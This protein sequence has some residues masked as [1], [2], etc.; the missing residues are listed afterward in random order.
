MTTRKPQFV[1]VTY[2]QTTPEKVWAALQDPEL[3][4]QFWGMH[5]NV[6]DWKAGS[7]WSHQDYETNEVHLTGQV[8]EAE[9]PKKLV[10]T[11]GWPEGRPGAEP[12][13]KVTFLLE[14]FMGSVRLTVMHDELVEG[15]ET[16]KGISQGW[17][18][19]LSSLKSLL[20]T[21]Q[22]LAM[23]TKRWGG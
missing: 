6:S 18:A 2:I 16:M 13:S 22:P 19:I 20:E 21:G 1:Y 4:K 7:R 12:P 10:L 23:T 3:T 9:P 14:P 5:K 11:W 17:P 8:L 15:G